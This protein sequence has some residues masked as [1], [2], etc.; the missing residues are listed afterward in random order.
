VEPDDRQAM[1][2]AIVQVSFAAA[3]EKRS[4]IVKVTNGLEN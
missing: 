3:P 1:L 2:E 4:L